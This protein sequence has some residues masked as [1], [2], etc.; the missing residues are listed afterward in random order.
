MTKNKIISMISPIAF[1]IFGIW[2]RYSAA[3][4]TSRDA[5]MPI[6]VSYLVILISIVDLITEWKKEKHK[7]R[8][9]GVNFG[10]IAA[11]LIAMYLYVFLLKKIGFYLDTLWLTAFTMLTLD[12]KN[13]KMLALSSVIITTVV[14][15][16]FKF[17]L[18]VPLPTLWI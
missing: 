14:F 17:L 6:I 1:L 10:R 4:M 9:A 16:A 15:V 7:D 5:M 8:F 3:S 13:Y 11:C 18:K 12:Y 2:I